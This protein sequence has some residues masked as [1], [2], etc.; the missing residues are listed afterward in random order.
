MTDFNAIKT[1]VDDKLNAL[2]I[3]YRAEFA[4]RTERDS[5][6]CFHWRITFAR[7]GKGAAYSADYYMGLAHVTAP[8][9]S[10]VDPKPIAPHAADVLHSLVLDA[11]ANE[12]SFADWADNYGYSDDS[13]KALRVYQDCCAIS[14]ELARLFSRSELSE[15]ADIVA[16]L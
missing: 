15:L 13:L 7:A 3:K 14:K 4:G 2:G 16:E 1:S 11:G 12:L 10:Y 9:H 8:K 6:K 5:W